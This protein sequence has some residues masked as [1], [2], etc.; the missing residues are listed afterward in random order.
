[1][2]KKVG[3]ILN[4]VDDIVNV[5]QTHRNTIRLMF[6]GWEVERIND[7]ISMIKGLIKK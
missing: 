1:M 6:G 5:Y 4:I 7:I 3:E 2:S